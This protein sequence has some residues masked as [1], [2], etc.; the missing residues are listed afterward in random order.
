M[1]TLRSRLA[2]LLLLCF[3]RVLLPDAW[4]LALHQHE[5]T[6]EESAQATRVDKAQDKAL[7][8]VQHQHCQ[9]DHFYNVPFQVPAPLELPFVVL[10]AHQEAVGGFLAD[11]HRSV[12]VARL[13][14]PPTQA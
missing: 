8:T 4:I 9:V 12:Q 3:T 13:R 11:A 14:G 6:L 5:H 1:R 2:L 10:Y 7:L